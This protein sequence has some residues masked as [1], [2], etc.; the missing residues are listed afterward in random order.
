MHGTCLPDCL[1]IVSPFIL[2]QHTVTHALCSQFHR[3]DMIAFQ[4]FQNCTV[5]RV[6]SG[7]NADTG[8]HTFSQKRLCRLQQGDLIRRFHRCEAAAEKGDLRRFQ[9]PAAFQHCLTGLCHLFRRG[10]LHCAADRSLVAE[11]ALVRTAPMGNEERQCLMLCHSPS[12][13]VLPWQPAVPQPFCCV[14]RLCR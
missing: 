2:I 1:C 6:R 4:P 11:A 7:G 9:R 5:Y 8:K 14:P 10:S 3:S 12:G 13:T